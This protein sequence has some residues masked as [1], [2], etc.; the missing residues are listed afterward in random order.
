MTTLSLA[1]AGQLLN[2]GTRID[3]PRRAQE[4]LDGAVALHH[5]LERHRVAYLADEVGMGKTYV[6]LAAVALFRHIHPEFRVCVI[7]PRK[8]IQKKWHDELGNLVHNNFCFPDLRTKGLDGRP[9]RPRVLCENLVEL[10]REATVDRERDF[11]CRLSSFSLG[12]SDDEGAKKKLRDRL[13]ASVPWAAQLLNARSSHGAFKEDF[14]RAVCCAL[15]RFDLVIVD[16]AHNLRGGYVSDA[17]ARNRV[18]AIAFGHPRGAPQERGRFPEYGPRAARVL[19]LSATPLE[20]DYR[21]LY[22]QLDIFGLAGDFGAL[23]DVDVD[24]EKKRELAAQFMIRR[25]TAMELAGARYTKNLYRQEWRHGGVE[26]HDEPLQTPGVRDRLALALVQKKVSELLASARF[27]AQ[28]QIG[29]LAS[30]ESF[31]E[32][33][34][35]NRDVDEGN[36]DDPEQTADDDE[37]EGIDVGAVNGLARDHR[38]H[39]D[40]ELPHP[41]MD[42]LVSALATAWQSGKKALVFVRRVASVGELK[43]KLDDKYDDWLLT[44]LRQRLPEAVRTTLEQQYVEYRKQRASIDSSALVQQPRELPADAGDEPGIASL[45]TADSG[46]HDTFFAWFFRGEGPEKVLSG[47]AI[48]RRFIQRGTV[49]S[50]FFEDN[51]AMWLLDAS[52]GTVMDRLAEATNLEPEGLRAELRHRAGAFLSNARSRGRGELFEAF[53]GAAVGLL[54]DRATGRLQDRAKTVWRHRYE[55]SV[56][57]TESATRAP[58]VGDYLELV[59][60]FTELRGRPELRKAIWPAS[61]SEDFTDDFLEQERRAALL[62]TAARLGHAF[63]DLYVLTIS[64]LGSLEEGDRNALEIERR[65]TDRERVAAY[66]DLLETQRVQ[67]LSERDWGAFDELAAA[68]EHFALI[69]DVNV[70]EARGKPIG[71]LAREFGRLLRQQQP[72]GGMSGQVNQTLVRQFRMPGYPF[73]L[74]TTDVLQE[75]EDLHTFCS[76]V[77]HYGIAWTP[78]AMEQRTGRIDR[79]L[80]QTERR[81]GTLDRAPRREELLQVYYPHLQDTVEVLQVQ[82]VLSRMNTFLRLMNRGFED[83]LPC[84]RKIDVGRELLSSAGYPPPITTLLDSAF[85]V[86]PRFLEGGRSRLARTAAEIRAIVTRFRGLTRHETLGGLRVSWDEGCG[87]GSLTGTAHLDDRGRQQPVALFL[88]SYDER[89]LVR[90]VSPVGRIGDIEARASAVVEAVGV[91][92]IEVGAIACR[93]DS[94]YDLTVEDDVLLGEESADAER[95]GWMLRRVV[96]QADDLELQCFPGVDHP[97]DAFR[98]ELAVEDGHVH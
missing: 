2:L 28:F 81:L 53:Q 40:A 22:N 35:R 16:E 47:A 74:V 6:A 56:L 90:C 76:S 10:V 24:Q 31:M 25:V 55:P 70:R 88:Q 57:R 11:F 4:Q 54:R 72:V 7:A 52:H 94:S 27:N 83:R 42:G 51:H 67:P 77:Y 78:S 17:A 75:G 79:V 32:T 59:T 21:H 37:R 41:K 33:A 84:E 34:V 63:I 38:K 68:A 26:T 44:R 15:P 62:S 13:K 69:C 14:A 46:G 65:A 43:R 80:S 3:N 71:E 19:F 9:A 23:A 29:M 39:F 48:Q 85:P 98:D 50:T 49:Y 60:F 66:L 95:V 30:F 96:Y 18:L 64:R 45:A 36:F 58:E 87:D 1:A 82:R 93:D 20:D 89:L 91:E 86:Q 5:I 12:L 61:T 8:N 73:V 97:L 92:R